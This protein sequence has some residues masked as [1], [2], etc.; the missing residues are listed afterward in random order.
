MIQKIFDKFIVFFKSFKFIKTKNIREKKI[1][2]KVNSSIELW[3]SRTYETKEP[4][5][6]DWIDSF[7]KNEIFYDIGAN[8]GIY[9]LYAAKKKNRVYSFEPASNNFSSLLK[10][11]EINKLNIRSYGIALSNKEGISNL[12]LVSTVE[13]DSQHNL[14]KNQMIYSRK[15]KFEQGIFSTSLDNL[16]HKY[17]FPFPNHIKID[18]DGHEQNILMGANKILKSK[19]LKSIMVEINFKNQKEYKSILKIMSKNKFLIKNKSKRIYTNKKIKA[20]NVYFVR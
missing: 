9:S 5:T 17:S 19:K 3:R 14:N 16:I 20:Q 2:I 8:I 10:N 12:N 7:K 4:E 18:V 13:G 11:I 1:Y 6:L 15:F